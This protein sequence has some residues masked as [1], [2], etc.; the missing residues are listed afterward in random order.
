MKSTMMM[1]PRGSCSVVD[2][3]QVQNQSRGGLLNRQRKNNVLSYNDCRI[4]YATDLLVPSVEFLLQ[5]IYSAITQPT[6]A[7]PA[8]APTGA[9]PQ[10]LQ[11]FKDYMHQ[12]VNQNGVN[13][14]GD[15]PVRLAA[16]YLHHQRYRR[17]NRWR[18]VV[19]CKETPVALPTHVILQ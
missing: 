16:W 9:I 7:L 13:Y 5:S 14:A 3:A 19:T 15:Q 6:T 4:L 1:T 8:A 10:A 17:C 2:H 11:N 12:N 18:M